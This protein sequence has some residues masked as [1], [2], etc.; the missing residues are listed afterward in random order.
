MFVT[1]LSEMVSPSHWLHMQHKKFFSAYRFKRSGIPVRNAMDHVEREYAMEFGSAFRGTELIVYDIGAADGVVA[2][3]LLKLAGVKYVHAF[4]PIPASFQKL[5]RRVAGFHNI[6]CH[7]VALGEFNDKATLHLSAHPDS[8]SLL[9]MTGLHVAEFPG[10]GESKDIQIEVV[11]LDDFI[12]SHGLALPDV[13]KIDVQGFELAVLKGGGTALAHAKFC[14]LEMSFAPLYEGSPL[15]DDIYEFM[16][17]NGFFLSG[18][19]NVTIHRGGKTLQI[20]GIFT[21]MR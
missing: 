8:S 3:A 17:A 5:T 19:G 16:K 11:R 21:R 18:T 6:S 1:M 9:P 7:N 2:R 4:E 14:V 15:F 20:D 12:A 13:L 10:S